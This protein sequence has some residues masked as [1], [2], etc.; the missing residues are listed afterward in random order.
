MN[1]QAD[2]QNSGALQSDA[3]VTLKSG[4]SIDN[5]GSMNS[6]GK[7]SVE[8]DGSLLNWGTITAVDDVT[9]DSVALLTNHGNVE[10]TDGSILVEGKTGVD[11]MANLLIGANNVE[12]KSDEGSVYILSTRDLCASSKYECTG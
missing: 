8:A 3:A 1:A 4:K 11:N 9:L 12:I 5:S 7:V 10:S 2:I 6:L